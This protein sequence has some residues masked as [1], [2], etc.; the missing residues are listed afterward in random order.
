MITLRQVKGTRLTH[1]KLDGNFED[2]DLR[3][4][5]NSSSIQAINDAI[6]DIL[7]TLSSMTTVSSVNGQTGAVVLDGADI[8]Y[9]GTASGLIANNIQDAI[10]EVMSSLD[11]FVV[12]PMTTA[13]DL[14]VGG[15]DGV[16]VRLPLGD[17]GQVL[18]LRL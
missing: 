3:V 8:A 4:L 9:D 17:E 11:D 7:N 1:A 16:P 18:S 15:T 5:N 10:D 14:I 2:L 12:N 6:S 13:G